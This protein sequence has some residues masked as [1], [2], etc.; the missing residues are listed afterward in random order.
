MSAQLAQLSTQLSEFQPARSADVAIGQNQL[1]QDVNVRLQAQ[2]QRI[3]SVTDNVKKIERD[4]ADNTKLLHDLVINMENLGESLK[5]I[6]SEV[7]DWEEDGT[8]METDEDKLY[9]DIQK[10]LLQEVSLSF[11]H[12]GSTEST[13]ISIAVPIST[14]VLSESSTSVLP[15]SADQRMKDQLVNLRAP[16]SKRESASNGF[17]S[18]FSFST[19]TSATLPYPGLDGHPRRITPIPVSLPI[20]PPITPATV[21]KSFREQGARQEKEK[22]SLRPIPAPPSKFGWYWSELS[23]R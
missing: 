17:N 10:A 2:S 6:K 20:L 19:P 1:S 22:T 9:H 11:P 7:N 14:P 16:V 23:K 5:Q 12:V 15:E 3:D 13:P 21:V 8:P 18:S 4:S